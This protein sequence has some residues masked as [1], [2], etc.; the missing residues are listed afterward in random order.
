MFRHA[1][2]A[3]SALL[4]FSIGNAHAQDTFALLPGEQLR[5]SSDGEQPR[6]G[7]AMAY[8]TYLGGRLLVG[9]PGEDGTIDDVG[10][11][12]VFKRVNGSWQYVVQI[13]APSAFR[14]ADAGSARR[15]P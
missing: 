3:V 4:F 6:F 2:I 7:T 15:S 8:T 14:Q 12:I 13:L 9:L 1:S 11:T 5:P 10:A